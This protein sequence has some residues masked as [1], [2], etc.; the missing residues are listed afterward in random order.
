MEP[1]Y[2]KMLNTGHEHQIEF[3]MKIRDVQEEIM[4]ELERVFKGK[5]PED[6]VKV[7]EKGKREIDLRC[8][9]IAMADVSEHGWATVVEYKGSQLADNEG[10]SRKIEEAEKKAGRK[11]ELRKKKEEGKKRVEAGRFR[12]REVGRR[13]RSVERRRSLDRDRK[14]GE[15]KKERSK[16]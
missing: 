7:V 10:D 11:F 15:V 2:P 14:G 8:K 13:S 9:Y 16:S 4:D 3:N 1:R 12:A 6:L 5:V